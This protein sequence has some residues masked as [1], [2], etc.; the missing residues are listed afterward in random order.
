MAVWQITKR[1]GPGG[2]RHELSA[3]AVRSCMAFLGAA[4]TL[5][6]LMS[7]LGLT[8]K[9]GIFDIAVVLCSVLFTDAMMRTG[10]HPYCMAAEA[11]LSAVFGLIRYKETV[12]AGT[13]LMERY[14]RILAGGAEALTET[15][16]GSAAITESMPGLYADAEIDAALSWGFAAFGA[17][18]V[19]ILVWIL[20][21]K[22][23]RFLPALLVTGLFPALCVAAGVIPAYTYLA[24]LCLFWAM[25]LFDADELIGPSL[26]IM[27]LACAVFL[28]VLAV[29][30]P[31]TPHDPIDFTR[32]MGT[33][34]A[35]TT[36][37]GENNDPVTE[38]ESDGNTLPNQDDPEDAD[39]GGESEW[40][41]Q[42]R[43]QNGMEIPKKIA[44]VLIAV[45][46]T[47]CLLL[48]IPVTRLLRLHLRRKK[49]HS[50]DRNAAAIAEY[51]YMERLAAFAGDEKDMAGEIWR[52]ATEIGLKARFSGGVI[53][54]DEL[55]EM[56]RLSSYYRHLCMG[57]TK[58]LKFFYGKYCLAL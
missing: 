24:M 17:V 42:G 43:D 10:Y 20:G 7:A 54:G 4:G 39:P 6:C 45:L 18:L 19:C 55:R 35:P 34:A 2:E 57:R 8:L 27:P 40:R 12:S 29:G 26:I 37:G 13:I 49:T 38:T 22:I 5:G 53:S 33:A 25:L 28:G 56:H 46:A 1:T 9:P 31:H 47:A 41:P 51:S 32:P 52:E 36:V 14:A 15:G 23:R 21:L 11:G 58:G 48:L 30:V 44:R 3:F 16:G 50:R